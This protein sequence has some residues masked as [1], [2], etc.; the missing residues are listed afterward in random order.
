MNNNES[1]KVLKTVD[2]FNQLLDVY[3]F[4][5][6][7]KTNKENEKI[8]M[9]NDMQGGNL[10]G[11]EQE[12]FETLED[13]MDRLD[14]YHE[15]YIY[16]SLEERYDAG[17]NIPKDDWDLTAKRYIESN[18]I[19]E[20]LSNISASKYDKIKDHLLYW[21]TKE[22]GKILDEENLEETEEDEEEDEL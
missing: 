19:A 16:R 11:I 17:E 1:Q 13:I 7:T 9:L 2:F 14:S 3:E 15:D 12:E 8:F 6:Y 10:G 21:D 18:T 20:I 22:I 4:E 5:L